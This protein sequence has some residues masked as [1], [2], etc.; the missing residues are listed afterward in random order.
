MCEK[1]LNLFEQM[2]GTT[3]NVIYI[4]IF[5]ACAQLKNKRAKHIGTRLLDQIFNKSKN[6]QVVL[7]SAIHML[8]SFANVERAEQVFKLI[9]KKDVISYGAMMKGD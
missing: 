7:T 1:A 2:S 9:K 6:N 4:M 8:M 5:D 3:D